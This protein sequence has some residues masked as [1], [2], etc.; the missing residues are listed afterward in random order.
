M[1]NVD[2]LIELAIAE[3]MPNGDITSENLV[4]ESHSSFA[5][6]TAKEDLI[7]C[8]LDVAKK[9]FKKI[10]TRLNIETFKK[11]GVG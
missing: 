10:D 1:E 8:G 6:I 2:K 9:V 7:I 11:D 4:P 3:D 5:Q